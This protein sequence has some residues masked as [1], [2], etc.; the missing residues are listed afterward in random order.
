M[1]VTWSVLPG[2]CYLACVTWSVRYLVVRETNALVQSFPD[3]LGLRHFFVSDQRI[4]PIFPRPTELEVGEMVRE[5]SA[6]P[7]DANRVH[8]VDAL[9]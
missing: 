2:F 3:E 6:E 1:V 4:A 5:P 9:E 7:L 8:S